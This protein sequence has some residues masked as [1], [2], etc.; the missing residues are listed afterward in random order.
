MSK[1]RAKSGTASA[2]AA[3]WESGLLATPF[4]EDGWTS[5]VGAVVPD[6]LPDKEY[7]AF[8]CS[9]ISAKQR[10][11][12]TLVTYQGLIEEVQE[13]GNPKGKKPKDVPAFAEICETAKV[14]LDNGEPIP[15]PL[16]AKLVKWKL[17]AI[18]Q[19]DQKRRETEQKDTSGKESKEKKSGKKSAR[20]K[21]AKGKGKKTPEVPSP[22][23]EST[24]KKRG[25]EDEE[26]KYIDDEPDDGPQHYILLYG[27]LD[28]PLL[29]LLSDLG[30]NVNCI[31]R[32][33]CEDYSL[34]QKRKAIKE[35]EEEEDFQKPPEVLEAEQK[36]EAKSRE[37]LEKFWKQYEPL[38]KRAPKGS[39]LHDI[40]RIKYIVKNDMVPEEY[41]DAENQIE[42]GTALFEDIACVIYDLL[43][44]NR[45]FQNY[46]TNMKLVQ[47]NP[48][49][50]QTETQLTTSSTTAPLAAGVSSSA[51]Q[52]GG[53]GDPQIPTVPGQVDVRYY[54][55]LMD[56]IPAESCSVPLIMHCMLEQVVAT[57]ETKEPPSAKLTQPRADGLDQILAAQIDNIC[58][59]FNFK[60]TDK[61]NGHSSNTD[62]ENHQQFPV[63]YHHG[64]KSSERLRHL[65]N[66]DGFDSLNAELSMLKLL[67]VSRVTK[68]PRPSESVIKQRSA[69]LHELLFQCFKEGTDTAEMDQTLR[70]FVFESLILRST[71]G[72]GR[73][74]RDRADQE[75]LWDDPYIIGDKRK[76][77]PSQIAG[78][79]MRSPG[80]EM[81]LPPDVI[82]S[83]TPGILKVE[84]K[85]RQGSAGSIRS[86]KSQVHFEDGVQ[87]QK[88]PHEAREVESNVSVPDKKLS[89][90]PSLISVQDVADQ[91]QRNLDEWC[92][93]EHLKPN[94]LLQVLDEARTLCPFIDTYYH[95]KDHSLLIVMHNPTD[96][97]RKNIIS[98]DAKLHS[99]VGFRNYLEHVADY[100]DDWTYKEEQKYQMEM[101]ER[102]LAAELAAA[103]AAAAASSAANTPS[104]SRP[105]SSKGRNRSQ[106]PKKSRSKSPK[107][108]SSE[109]PAPAANLDPNS[110]GF[111]RPNSMKSWKVEHDRQ[112]AEEE[113]KKQDKDKKGG[114]K[115]ARS[116]SSSPKK[117][118]KEEKGKDKKDEGKKRGASGR[119]SRK[120]DKEKKEPAENEV[121]DDV[122]FVGYD[123]GNNMI[124]ANGTLTSM[125]PTEGG[126]VCCEK[127]EFINGEKQVT[128]PTEEAVQKPLSRFGSL[129][130]SL[131]D[132]M[133]LSLSSYGK[134]GAN[135]QV[136]EEKPLE[137]I[138]IPPVASPSPPPPPTSSPKGGR[139]GSGKKGKKGAPAMSVVAESE[140]ASQK[141]SE[142]PKE[143]ETKPPEPAP[144]EELKQP[145]YQQLFISCPNGLHVSYMLES[146]AGVKPLSEDDPGKML[147]KQSYPSK[148]S[149]RQPCEAPIRNPAMGEKC[150]YITKEGAVIKLMLDGNTEVLFPTGAVSRGYPSQVMDG[151]ASP[152]QSRD[153]SPQRDGSSMSNH[154]GEGK[155]GNMKTSGSKAGIAGGVDSLNGDAGVG[156]GIAPF[157]WVTTTVSGDRVSTKTGDSP[158]QEGAVMLYLATDPVT[159]EVM[160]TREDKVIIVERPDGTR[161]VD[162]SDGTRITSYAVNLEYR[163]SNGQEEETGK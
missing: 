65:V 160:T 127:T 76:E 121:K 29:V 61:Q 145:P 10:K 90:T 24:L 161:I 128:P 54:N 72:N 79:Q 5:F 74:Q 110:G 53:E 84:S 134:Y 111:M 78:E 36:A 102:E 87:T 163:E 66:V 149:G 62:T 92:F 25:E 35:E 100:I 133:V 98:W 16:L 40:A 41:E 68:F 93:V 97:E 96:S 136:T 91:P 70:K 120:G 116:R 86:S 31:L 39:S 139:G 141:I 8:L 44:K 71:D 43:D 83:T 154:L 33:T 75:I 104:A 81:S 153:A 37:E 69:R 46:K 56:C 147:I 132:G 80:G 27:F 38:L 3:R 107:G 55:D 6:Q 119:G 123:V 48:G 22:K 151:P 114:R 67:P 112:V 140:K 108:R 117:E 124:H 21:S 45:Q 63:F 126:L 162:H 2:G 49:M 59:K 19:E 20:G 11:L 130:A 82:R 157:E 95:R 138:E 156:D 129:T 88:D 23:K 73:V 148:T 77:P 64:D 89:P 50:A 7:A 12:Y 42:F 30:I 60:E 32:F 137:E 13:L 125:F 105:G 28:A 1:K 144:A 4:E 113:K 94:V 150:R 159:E 34:F 58:E 57:E 103:Q 152:T 135:P 158:L 52:F 101:R 142:P 26:N 118:D 146:M 115:S 122:E 143:E 17:L 99:D 18:K 131:N 109:S 15:L 85:S 14:H 9:C 155:K 106:S 51:V 47:I